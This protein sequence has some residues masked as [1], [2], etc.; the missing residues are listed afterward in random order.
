MSKRPRRIHAPAF[1]A[2][3]ALA[4]LKGKEDAGR[5]GPTIRCAF[6]FIHGRNVQGDRISGRRAGDPHDISQSCGARDRRRDVDGEMI[7]AVLAVRRRHRGRCLT[8]QGPSH[9]GLAAGG[10]S[11]PASGQLSRRHPTGISSAMAA[12]G[13]VRFRRDDR[14][15]RNA[16]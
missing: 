2:K 10:T 8:A 13:L 9:T 14:T 7:Q 3:V 1:K 11:P 5:T 6:G 12:R 4:A 16:S 15:S